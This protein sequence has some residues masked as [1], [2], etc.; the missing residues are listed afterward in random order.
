MADAGWSAPKNAAHL[1]RCGQTVRDLLKDFHGRE[2]GAF[3]PRRPGPP[4]DAARRDRVA[5]ELRRLLAEDR[6]WT[7][8]Q[9]SEALVGCGVRLGP[10]QLRRHLKRMRARYR[11]TAS[12]LK[13]GWSGRTPS[14]SREP[15]MCRPRCRPSSPRSKVGDRSGRRHGASRRC[16]GVPPIRAAGPDDDG[17]VHVIEVV[18]AR[19][20]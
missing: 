10:R 13:Q 17:H 12:T 4:P 14:G 7:S 20:V 19:R 18:V 1:G 3:Q 2:T 15:R 6:T 8:H 11:R 16:R 5:E 9:L